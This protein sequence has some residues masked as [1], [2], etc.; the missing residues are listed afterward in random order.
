MPKLI[1]LASGVNFQRND[2]TKA[3]PDV[4]L[5]FDQELGITDNPTKVLS[6]QLAAA[7]TGWKG[8]TDILDRMFFNREG[9]SR[10]ALLG[11]AHGDQGKFPA[12][13]HLSRA[14][15]QLDPGYKLVRTETK[16]KS[17][18]R[19][20]AMSAD[21]AIQKR[22]KQ[23]HLELTV[24]DWTGRNNTGEL[25]TKRLYLVL[26]FAQDLNEAEPLLKGAARELTQR[27]K[28]WIETLVLIPFGNDLV[29][30]ETA[31]ASGKLAARIA[32]DL[33]Q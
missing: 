9:S 33:A 11:L 5:A 1:L 20:W 15:E 19:S 29:F 12:L 13:I 24:S 7:S 27:T 4:A 21:E 6:P 8:L 26:V 10:M 32:K 30:R 23:G 3:K 17:E 18:V 25:T 16:K 31:E 2:G 22:P 14:I 28:D